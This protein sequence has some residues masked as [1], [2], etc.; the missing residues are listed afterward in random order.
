MQP[1]YYSR[2]IANVT[3]KTVAGTDCGTVQNVTTDAQTITLP[4]SAAGLV[5]FSVT[6]R[7]GGTNN[8]DVGFTVAPAAADGVNGLG[9]TSAVN[10][11]VINTKATARP[12]DEITLRCSGVTGVNAWY[13]DNNAVGTFARVP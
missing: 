3:S 6:V 4:A 12:G 9:F 8:G 7:N 13:I 10:K 11:G 2:N 5:G 1:T